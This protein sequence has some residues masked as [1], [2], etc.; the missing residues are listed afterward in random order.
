[1]E[2]TKFLF[3]KDT[4][5]T[6][7]VDTI[8]FDSNAERDNFFVNQNHYKKMDTPP[9]EFNFL[10][11]RSTVTV[12][13]DNYYDW[14]GVNYCTFL[15]GFD[16]KRYY[17]FV[18]KIAYDNS[19]IVAT[20]LIDVVMTFTQGNVLESLNNLIIQR[21]HLD[22]VNYKKYLKVLQ[23][24]NDIIETKTNRY[25]HND[26]RNFRDIFVVFQSAVDLTSDFGN[27][28]NPDYDTSDGGS[29][30]LLASPI[31]VYILRLE[32]FRGLMEILKK[33][34]W[35]AQNITVVNVI[36]LELLNADSMVEVEMASPNHYTI[37]KLK[38]GG[39]SKEKQLDGLNYDLLDLCDLYGIDPVQ[40]MHLL[41]NGY[42][43]LELYSWD[44]QEVLL[45]PAFL[46][47]NTGL[48]LQAKAVYGY[49]NELR[50]FPLDYQS[51]DQEKNY[52]VDDDIRIYK[53]TFLNNCFVF[54]NFTSLPIL[55]DNAQLARAS[56]ANR[57]QLEESKLLTN[58]IKDTFS[59]K[60]TITDKFFNAAS[61]LSDLSPRG[62]LGK[63]T[64]EYEFYRNQKAEFADNKLKTPTLSSQNKGN[65]FQISNR[66]FGITLKLSAPKKEELDIVRRYYQALGYEMNLNG[67]KLSD[68]HSMSVCNY[69]Q[70]TG[71]FYLPDVPTEYIAMLKPLFE[72]GVRF[73]HNNNTGYPM[74]TPILLNKI[75]R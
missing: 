11:D 34:S 19:S 12:S 36:P 35:V 32:R 74:Q 66:I 30:D 61:V 33:Y 4:P 8:H 17:A 31:D 24:N 65:A 62:L 44:G 15:S 46:D 2:L 14:T 49:Q 75:R 28:D 53:G 25:I 7:F 70:F 21:Q 57:R 26:L 13:V 71:N 23:T 63:M 5:L 6:N 60:T 52:T 72:N 39:E 16:N 38:D 27:K 55:V 59:D 37:Y 64:D 40:E 51:S 45:D 10:R 54:D 22:F 48:Q 42:F 47:E 9:R 58:R 1:M 43:T 20:L 50:V 41:R 73:W 3:F 69:L 67:E 18:T 29:F 56:T 68:V